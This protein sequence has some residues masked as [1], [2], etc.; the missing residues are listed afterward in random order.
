LG[1]AVEIPYEITRCHMYVTTSSCFH[2]SLSSMATLA[3][4]QRF[5]VKQ[6]PRIETVETWL[7][8]LSLVIP[9]KGNSMYRLATR[10]TNAKHLL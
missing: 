9:G 8:S 2:L 1:N 7:R 10:I 3:K 5:L 6:A 4:Y